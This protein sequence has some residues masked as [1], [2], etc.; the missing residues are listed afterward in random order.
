M[1]GVIQC[2]CGLKSAA[3]CLAKY[4]SNEWNDNDCRSLNSTFSGYKHEPRV[5]I[6]E[7][8]KWRQ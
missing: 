4:N 7:Q 8:C 5:H 3:D 1:T 6:K 2:Y